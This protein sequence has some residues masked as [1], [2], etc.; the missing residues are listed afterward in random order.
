MQL[1]AKKLEDI[2]L[3]VLEPYLEQWYNIHQ[4]NY[5]NSIKIAIFLKEK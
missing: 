1:K 5:Y 4:D 3:P 2:I